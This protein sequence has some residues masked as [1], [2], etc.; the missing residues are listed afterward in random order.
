MFCTAAPGREPG[1]S[2]RSLRLLQGDGALIAC[3]RVAAALLGTLVVS[4]ARWQMAL[5]PV[6]GGAWV[7]RYTSAEPSE[8]MR[9]RRSGWEAYRRGA[10]PGDR[11]WPGGPGG[12]GTVQGRPGTVQGRPGTVQ[13][14]PGTVQGR[15]N[16]PQRCKRPAAANER[17][18]KGGGG[19][20]GRR[21]GGRG[22]GG[23]WRLRSQGLQNRT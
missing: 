13:G 12:P 18:K 9:K 5:Q 22:E 11:R 19:V 20:W 15:S 17:R 14:R 21:G 1:R 6:E 10:R 3:A 16:W 23:G 7:D 2:A 8:P 4:P